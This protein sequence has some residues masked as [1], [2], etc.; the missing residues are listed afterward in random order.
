VSNS[1]LN[2]SEAEATS[3]SAQQSDHF[4]SGI[5]FSISDVPTFP[6]TPDDLHEAN[7]DGLGC[8]RGIQVAFAFEGATALLIYGIW[9]LWHVV[10]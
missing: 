3:S 10:R 1:T 4:F 6:A 5:V 2:A 8:L 7:R 9:H